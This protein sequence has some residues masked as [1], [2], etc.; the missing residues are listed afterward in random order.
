VH[1]YRPSRLVTFAATAALILSFAISA[2]PAAAA[3]TRIV[4]I[5]SSVDC[6][7]TQPNDPNSTLVL[8][9]VS[10]G[11]HT[12]FPLFVKN[13]GG[14][15]LNNITL[16]VGSQPTGAGGALLWDVL[17]NPFTGGTTIF[18]TFGPS[19]GLCKANN[20]NTLLTCSTKTLRPGDSISIT[21]VLV[22]P[23]SGNVNVYAAAKVAENSNDAGANEDTFEAIA[24][25]PFASGSSCDAVFTFFSPHSRT[26]QTCVLTDPANGN[27]ESATIQY[28]STLNTKVNVK[29]T[30]TDTNLTSPC[31]AAGAPIGSDVVADITGE[32]SSETVT[33]TLVIDL[34]ALK[35]SSLKE[36]DITFCHWNDQGIPTAVTIVSTNITKQGV[37]TLVATTE[38]NGVGRSVH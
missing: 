30:A 8:S 12:S 34:K 11:A 7:Q 6:T 26:A 28:V 1:R 20:A 31:A 15:N 18:E 29:E 27:S 9:P 10:P 17:A 35:L 13:C 21:V 38:G 22:A 25:Q 2:A 32:S 5:G 33:W 24:H 23:T 36:A 37:L 4:Q 16:T 3:D 14:Q 19:A